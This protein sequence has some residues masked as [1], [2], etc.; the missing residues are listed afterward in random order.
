MAKI[1][2][3]KVKS[4]LLKSKFFVS[5]EKE[6]WKT[7]TVPRSFP[8]LDYWSKKKQMYFFKDRRKQ[9]LVFLQVVGF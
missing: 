3:E 4:P 8:S 6:N 9:I 1:G 5:K 2:W 7:A